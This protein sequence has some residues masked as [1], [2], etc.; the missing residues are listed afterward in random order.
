MEERSMRSYLDCYLE[1]ARNKP[2]LPTLRDL[3]RDY[4]VYLLEVTDHNVTLVSRILDISRTAVYQKI[5]RYDIA[6]PN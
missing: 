3:E 4:I 1:T 5:A 2:E 6:R